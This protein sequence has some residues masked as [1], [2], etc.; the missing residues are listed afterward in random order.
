MLKHKCIAA[1]MLFAMS[2]LG[3]QAQTRS[4]EIATQ[5]RELLAQMTLEEKVGQMN[6]LTLDMLFDF[7]DDGRFALVQEKLETALF[8]HHIGS[9]LNT[10]AN[11]AQTRDWWCQLITQIQ[12][13]AARTRLKI[14]VLYGI[15]AIHGP[16]YTLQGT[17]FP[18]SI[19]MAATFN[20]ELSR[21]SGAI[22]AAEIKAC[23][24]AWNFY[25]VMDIGRQPLWSRLWETYGEDVYLAQ[26]M[27]SAYIEG[28]Q[29]SDIGA[30]DKAATCLKHYV[31]Y[32]FPNNG[33]DR[34]PAWI[35]DRMLREY[36][37]PTFAAGIRA[38]A[39]TVMVNSGEVDGIPVHSSHYLL[40]QVLRNELG[41]TG[42]AVSDWEDIKR[43]HTRDHVA[44]TPKEAVRMAVMA[45]IDMS[46]V[47][48]DASFA[49]LLAELVREGKVPMAR[50]DEAVT[51]ILTVKYELG[52]F[53]NALPDP[54]LGERFATPASQAV[55]LEA[56][57]QSIILARNEGVLPLA[58]DIKVLVTGPNADMLSV[59]N[60]GWTITWQGTNESLYPKDKPTIR[61]AIVDKIGHDRVIYVPGVTHDQSNDIASAVAAMKD[62]DVAVVC[63]G[64]TAYCETPGNIHDLRL[65]AAQ[66]Q[67]AEALLATGKRVII[68]MSGGRPRVMSEVAE[69]AHGVVL[70]FLPGIEGGRAIA[71]VLFGD[72]N[73]SGRLP[74]TY[75][76]HVN[77]NTTYDHKWQENLEGNKVR[78]LF[79]FGHG[80]SYTTFAYSDLKLDKYEYRGEER[81]YV[82]L[83]VSNTG[84]SAGHEAVLLYLT[85]LYAEVSRPMRQLRRFTKIA[86]APGES[87]EVSFIL[88]R[89]DLSF[90]GRE[91]KRIV[92]AGDFQIH[93][94]TLTKQFKLVE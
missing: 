75:P 1:A 35:S 55:N 69:R 52:L 11:T 60:G 79:P 76:R 41:F 6:Q 80:L 57:R 49:T 33:L 15:D 5:V 68:V 45:G 64:E 12:Q 38:G 62:A 73:P 78:P 91:N 27:G 93:V 54:A 90:I 36:F 20:A 58:K 74:V 28:H 50:I 86:L 19:S 82:T 34:T 29:G 63:L 32:G 47:P 46:M 10:A 83:T 21:Q 72:V 30:R 66:L 8:R 84:K 53:T 42:F 43:L 87:R 3:M 77:G 48:Y 56:A 88:T 22:T 17:L 16:T 2:T 67:L 85:D 18:Q 13:T 25:P 70:A 23:G 44:A 39:R 65:P 24:I 37:L 4:E 92:E 40:T 51:R 9:L 26:T 89:D 71:D 7:T 59:L 61:R 31:G 94:G 14:P 81:I